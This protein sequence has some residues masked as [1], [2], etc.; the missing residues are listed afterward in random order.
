MGKWLSCHFRVFVRRVCSLF[1]LVFVCLCVCL[2]SCWFVFVFVCLCVCLSL[3]L[4][5]FAFVCF[6]VGLFLR[7]S[8]CLIRGGLTTY[9]PHGV[10][11][12]RGGL[13]AW[14]ELLCSCNTCGR[15][16]P[17]TRPTLC[18]AEMDL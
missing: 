2:S 8:V 12:G 15:L 6:C 3:C 13:S 9:P 18:L 16:D 5:V 1:F 17:Y 14:C 7:L 10:G 4:F 11:V